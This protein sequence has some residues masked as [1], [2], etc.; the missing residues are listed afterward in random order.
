MSAAELHHLKIRLHAGARHQAERG[1]LRHALPGGVVRQPDGA[2]TWHPDAEVQARVRLIFATFA[3]LGS[4]WAVRDDLARENLLV[5]SRP[6]RAPAPHET[7]W[8][9]AR[10]HAILRMLHHPAYAGVYVRGHYGADPERPPGSSHSRLVERPIE[11]WAVC[12][13]NVYP[14]YISWETYVANRAQ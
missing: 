14:A 1:A 4:A 9:P 6:L 5:P 12:V 10:V 3:A 13:P 8:S 11:Q 2:V 7:V